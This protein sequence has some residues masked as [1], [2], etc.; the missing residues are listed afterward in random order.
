MKS[1]EEIKKLDKA[2][3]LVCRS[4][5][6]WNFACDLLNYF[7]SCNWFKY[8]EYGNNKAYC[9][10]SVSINRSC[11]INE[12]KFSNYILYETADFMPNKSNINE[13]YEIY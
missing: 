4:Q 6:E 3:V 11:T 12:A 1:I 5:E 2:F 9:I 7:P 10:K 13:N 8:P